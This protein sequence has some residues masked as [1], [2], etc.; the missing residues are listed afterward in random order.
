LRQVLVNL[1]GNA[2]KF[3]H[4]GG[5]VIDATVAARTDSGKITLRFCVQ[6]TGIGIAPEKTERIFQNFSQADTSTA[7]QYGG[8]GLGLAISKQLVQMMGG[9]IWFESELEKGSRFWFT[10]QVR[11]GEKQVRPE[12]GDLGEE[13]GRDFSVLVVEDNQINQDL[14][15][16]VLKKHGYQVK[17]AQNGCEALEMVAAEAFDIIL[18][19]VQ[20]PEMDG[21]TA[22][23]IIRQCEKGQVQALG[24]TM[25]DLVAVLGK[26]LMGN[27]I[28]II[29]MTANAMSGDREQCLDAGMDDYLTKPFMP[30]HITRVF[31]RFLPLEEKKVD[32]MSMD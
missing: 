21:L 6:D 23:R 10:I 9:R 11:P 16:I 7:R 25:P 13:Q 17:L 24:E 12:K 26:K 22:T 30:D 29:A 14:A 20:M 18:M 5:V 2:I 3:T 31:K 19:D 8:S 27:H 15:L 4:E 28:P 1:I 32:R